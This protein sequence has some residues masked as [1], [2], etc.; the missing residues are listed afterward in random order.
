MYD[1]VIRSATL[2]DAAPLA[3]LGARTFRDTFAA[4]NRPEDMEA[5]IASHQET[6]N[7]FLSK[8]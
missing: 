5:Y 7:R 3:E 4:D 8:R 1:F 2:G 6:S